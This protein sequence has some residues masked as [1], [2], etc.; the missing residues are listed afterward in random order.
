LAR[1]WLLIIDRVLLYH[2]DRG[3]PSFVVFLLALKHSTHRVA[4][5]Y[6]LNFRSTN[7]A[8]TP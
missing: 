7:L 4:V 5:P 2:H 8:G 1:N 3:T 6:F